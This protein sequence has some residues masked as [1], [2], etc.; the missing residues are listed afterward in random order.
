MKGRKCTY[1]TD[2]A[3]YGPTL[4]GRFH[5]WFI[6]KDKALGEIPM[7]LIEAENGTMKYVEANCIKF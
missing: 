3:H 4:T 6:I 1:E 5:T 7:A 2:L